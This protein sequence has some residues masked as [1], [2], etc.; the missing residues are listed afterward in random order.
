[1]KSTASDVD[2]LGFSLASVCKLLELFRTA[3]VEVDC[4]GFHDKNGGEWDLRRA[5]QDQ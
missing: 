5:A 3:G 2:A 1:M 4:D